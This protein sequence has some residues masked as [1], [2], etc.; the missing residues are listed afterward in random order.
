MN[1]L[2]IPNRVE[3]SSDWVVNRNWDREIDYCVWV[4]G[5]A[6][7]A[8][9]PVQPQSES[10]DSSDR[11]LSVSEWHEW[12]TRVVVCRDP[13]LLWGMRI[14]DSPAVEIPTLVSYGKLQGIEI[15]ASDQ[16]EMI[17]LQAQHKQSAQ[18]QY[19]RAIAQLPR[20]VSLEQIWSGLS[21][22]DLWAGSDTT[23]TWLNE[24]WQSYQAQMP[25]YPA[26]IETIMNLPSAEILA[27]LPVLSPATE[28]VELYLIQSVAPQWYRCSNNGGLIGAPADAD[29]TAVIQS[30]VE[31]VVSL[32]E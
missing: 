21:A 15:S 17:S 31:L 16:A 3:A 22:I 4:L 11:I 8:F 12:I 14:E 7:L 30:M 23:R 6:E 1:Y 5:Q 10:R 19:E 27:Q 20:D 32:S 2:E 13:R 28:S 26:S 18:Q 25:F 24:Q 9:P 29:P